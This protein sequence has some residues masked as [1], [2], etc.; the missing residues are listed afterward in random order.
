[1]DMN[2]MFPIWT[3]AFDSASD[4]DWLANVFLAKG[5]NSSHIG[6]IRIKDAYCMPSGIGS[7]SLI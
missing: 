5:Y 3:E 7:L 2:T 1:M 4:I 6:V